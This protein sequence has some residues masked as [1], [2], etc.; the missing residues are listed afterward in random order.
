M[1][2]RFISYDDFIILDIL[3]HFKKFNLRLISD[4]IGVGGKEGAFIMV[5]FWLV[6]AMMR[7][8]ALYAFN[9]MVRSCLLNHSSFQASK[10]QSYISNDPFLKNLRKTAAAHFDMV[11]S[12]ANHLG[13]FSE[14]VAVS[15]EQIG[16]TPQAFSHLAC[17][18]AAMNLGADYA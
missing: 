11:L 1:T 2:A 18:S 9:Y 6:E 10:C 5:T 12:F 3:P 13:M 17:V 7:V 8:S 16:N 4:L 15:G 14:E